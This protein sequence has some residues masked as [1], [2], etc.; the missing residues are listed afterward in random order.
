MKLSVVI[1]AYN[2]EH[3]LP[4]TLDGLIA[5][6]RR[7]GVAFEIVIVNDNS[8]D[9][10]RSFVLDRLRRDPEL[11]LVD[12]SPPG[13]F[14]RAIRAGLR[15]VSGN[16]VAVVMADRSDDPEDVVRCYRKLL[17]GYDC[18]FGSRFRKGSRVVSYPPV[19]L[20]VNR[21]VNKLLQVLFATPFNDLT[22]AFKMYRRGALDG[23]G[24]LEAC[25]FNITIELSLSCVIRGYR[26]A[27]IPISW[28]GRTW[29]VSNLKLREMGRRYLATL[30]KIWFERL[31][32][33]DDIIA[34]AAHGRTHPVAHEI[35]ARGAP[36]GGL[37]DDAVSRNG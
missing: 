23:L 8:R 34:E 31:L 22:N 6:L 32:I 28:Y 30:L 27:E 11:V 1:P 14:G 17:E 4:Q 37:S 16:A 2:E 35:V 36:V 33:A 18:V 25:H 10:T 26:I 7:E 15:S 19:K 3:N 13:G 5:V 29:G 24:P 12:N 21:A 9:N 20:F